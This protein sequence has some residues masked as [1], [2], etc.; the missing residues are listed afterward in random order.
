MKKYKKWVTSHLE[1]SA[2]EIN[3]EKKL[4]I[5][6]L[7]STKCEDLYDFLHEKEYN[8]PYAT[9]KNRNIPTPKTHHLSTSQKPNEV[10]RSPSRLIV[11]ANNFT[12][13][14]PRLG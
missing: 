9:L 8:F 4:K 14:F 3:R 6:E 11:S 2:K 13:A 5:F 12:P 7:A 10:E 1:T